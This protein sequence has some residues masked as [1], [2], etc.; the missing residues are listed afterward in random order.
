MTF[1]IIF[2]FEMTFQK[3]TKLSFLFLCH[4]ESMG[5]FDGEETDW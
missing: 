1:F 2:D 4:I 3:L 5:V